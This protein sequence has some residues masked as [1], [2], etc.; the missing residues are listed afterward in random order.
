MSRFSWLEMG[1][2][3]P[4]AGEKAL[5]AERPDMDENTCLATATGFFRQGQYESA[6]Q[7]YSRAL[8]YALDLEEA[9][10]GQVQCLLA[11][12][13]YNEAN[14]WAD[15]A[16]ER[17]QN[18]PDLL[19]CKAMAAGR[20][21]GVPVGM[22]YSDASL[23][24]KG[25]AVGPLPWIVRGD[26][27]IGS[28]DAR[29]GALRCFNKA[30]ELGGRDW[31]THYL[32]GLALMREGLTEQALKRFSE[33]VQLERNSALLYC[34]M[35]Q[36]HE[37]LGEVREALLAYRRAREAD[38]TCKPARDKVEQL[39]NVGFLRRAWRSIVYRRG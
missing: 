25:R 9:W 21:R 29:Q 33:G 36:C 1:N 8:R 3:L 2:Q 37:A 32:I 7:W 11:L 39:R 18:S 17:F 31:F 38:P 12:Y 28:R 30:L 24:I 34:A 20:S 22:G 13:E 10:V 35:G 4:L 26:L 15:R 27:L 6:L 16:L 19:A 23:E 14:I 5:G